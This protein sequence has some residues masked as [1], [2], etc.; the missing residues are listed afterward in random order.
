MKSDLIQLTG[1]TGK[2]YWR[3]LGELADTES[4]RNWV[5]REFPEGASE[6]LDSTSRR[7]LLKLMGASFGLAGLTACRRPEQNILPLSRGVEGYVPGKA[8]YYATSISHGGAVT[9]LVVETH[10]GRPTK[11]EGNPDH[12]F[13]LGAANAFAQASV[14]DLY[15]PDRSPYILQDGKKVEPP[16]WSAAVTDLSSKLG[17]GDGLRFL[18]ERVTSPSLDAVRTAALQKYPKAKWVEYDPINSDQPLAA[19]Q[20]AFGEPMH[21]H[22][23][24]SKA[25]VIVSLDSD[26]LGLDTSTVLPIKQ[27]SKRRRVSNEA[28]TMNRL[29][30]VESQY[31]ITGAMADH[32]KRMRT[33]DIPEFASQLWN[34][35]SGLSVVGGNKWINALAKELNAKKGVSLVVAGPRQDVH[36]HL[37]ALQLNELLGNIGQTV[38]FYKT[39][40]KP[41]RQSSIQRAGRSAIRSQLEKG[42]DVDSLGDACRRDRSGFQMA[43]AAGALP[44][45][46]G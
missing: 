5:H 4:F 16:A 26:F 12:P 20:I 22:Y 1:E 8:Y 36:T 13:S 14:L 42:R 2:K 31:S 30:M 35:V 24:F 38:T 34:A 46:L 19:T 25:D 10:D 21:A 29:Y 44:G 27:F 6:M 3:S 7:T 43:R 40:R 32:R 11:I 23:D 15:D 41:W 45:I 39:S 17:Q 37:V 28:D 33:A 9:G 18:S